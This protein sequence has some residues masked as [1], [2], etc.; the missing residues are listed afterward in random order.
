MNNYTESLNLTFDPFQPAGN[1]NDFFAGG[2]RQQLLD[3]LIEH[4]IYS[5]SIVTVT[6]C[7]GCGKT[8]LANTFC[9]S[10]GDETVCVQIP[11][12]L[13]MNKSQF[14]EK[15]GE[16]IPV[17]LDDE[18]TDSAIVGIQRFVAQLDLEAKSLMIVIDDAHE[19]GS[20]VL[21]LVTCL[22]TGTTTGI[23][24]LLFGETQLTSMLRSALTTEMEQSLI[25][26][27]IA[28]LGV[29][30]TVDYVKFK[31]AEAGYT[32]QLPICASDLGNIHNSANGIPGT[33]NALV[34]NALEET[35]ITLSSVDNLQSFIYRGKNYWAIAATLI[36]LLVFT[37]VILAPDS[38]IEQQRSLARS[39]ASIDVSIDA[40]ANTDA[41]TEELSYEIEPIMVEVESPLAQ[42]QELTTGI[43]AD[44]TEA[45]NL[46]EQVSEPNI[47]AAIPE[48]G[49]ISTAEIADI[50]ISDFEKSLLEYPESSY[51]VQIM[52]S[53]S[54]ANVRR[55]IQEELVSSQ[56]GY[57]ETRF[58]EKPWFVV[59]LGQF[60]S[61]SDA[62]KAIEELP[63]PL[64][65]LQP[66]IR[67]ITDIQ[68]D[69]RELNLIN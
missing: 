49:E 55:F 37:F 54:E 47:T 12:T 40:Q 63:T 27:E 3:Q 44:I 31:L 64:R 17:H 58:Q 6:G 20:D 28:E 14:F 57:F 15:M 45:S 21:D 25:E 34:A 29:K 43:V 7:L 59:L 2:N 53:H 42:S 11:A 35:S 32:G 48:E 10:F 46:E 62:T 30:D 1:S 61:R 5:Q 36:V 9:Q 22:K 68:S 60:E 52:G 67:S 51:T 65:S 13:F 24:I 16:Q 41:I 19:L 23:H 56:R 38:R 18:G 33:I 8:T 69:I 50:D 4:S 26:F 39:E 66:W